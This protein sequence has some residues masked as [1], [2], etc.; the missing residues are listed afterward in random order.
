MMTGSTDTGAEGATTAP[1]R[2][3]GTE[4]V[5]VPVMQEELHLDRQRVETGRVRLT[6]TVQE[7]EVLVEQAAHRE[8]VQV[9]RVPVNQL[10]AEPLAVRYEGDTMIIPVV[11][12]VVVVEKRWRLKEEVRVTTRHISTPHRQP[13]RLRT[14]EVHVERIPS[15]APPTPA[16]EKDRPTE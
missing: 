2:T 3:E 15:A 10:V 8:E 5:V 16:G 9:E 7:R 11:E 12:E 14:E 4:T 13:V 1:A 6:K